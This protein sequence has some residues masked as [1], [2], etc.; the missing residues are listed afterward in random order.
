MIV[1]M[2]LSLLLRREMMVIGCVWVLIGGIFVMLAHV[3]AAS[4]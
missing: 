1:I 2:R 4:F 3:L